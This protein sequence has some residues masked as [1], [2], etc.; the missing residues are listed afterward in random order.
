MEKTYFLNESG[1]D[2]TERISGGYG[3][4]RDMVKLLEYA[5]KNHL[6]ILKDTQEDEAFF[7]SINFGEHKVSN[8]NKIARKIP[9]L[10]F[11]K[12]GFTDLAGGNLALVFE[13]EPGYPIA[14]VVMGSPT[15]EDRFADAEKLIWAAI[16]K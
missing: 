10:L 3:S 5:H 12:T 1:L 4:A 7:S 14:V 16:E 11:S 2:V 6:E 15:Q 13:K 9:L 8:T